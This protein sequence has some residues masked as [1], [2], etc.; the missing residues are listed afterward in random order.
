M[1]N[2]IL[3]DSSTAFIKQGYLFLASGEYDFF[4]VKIYNI[5]PILFYY[6]VYCQNLEAFEHVRQKHADIGAKV[7]NT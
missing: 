4:F 6:Q 2:K 3:Y 7:L 5:H 1:F